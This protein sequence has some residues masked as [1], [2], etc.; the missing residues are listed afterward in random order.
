MTRLFL[1]S[2]NSNSNVFFILILR[3][4]IPSFI[5]K[6]LDLALDIADQSAYLADA[7]S[8]YGIPFYFRKDNFS[9]EILLYTAPN[10]TSIEY[11]GK[12]ST[13]GGDQIT[14]YGTDF[15][16]EDVSIDESD[17]FFYSTVLLGDHE[18]FVVLSLRSFFVVPYIFM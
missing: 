11:S 1:V 17:Q 6:S 14:I 10:I 3:K 4:D 5:G 15:I 9:H 16:P 12:L 18:S 8:F 2:L 13:E 7:F